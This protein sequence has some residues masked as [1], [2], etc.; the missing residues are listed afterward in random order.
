MVAMSI[1]M[2]GSSALR[3]WNC[4]ADENLL[5]YNYGIL[6]DIVDCS[7]ITCDSGEVCLKYEVSLVNP[8]GPQYFTLMSS[9]CANETV[10]KAEYLCNNSSAPFKTMYDIIKSVNTGNA[11][12]PKCELSFCNDD[13]CNTGQTAQISLL[14]TT[15]ISLYRLLL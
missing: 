4:P 10:A 15:L 9:H 5:T 13:L 11:T 14:V 12:E 7:A 2:I 3:C 8:D 6:S 1:L